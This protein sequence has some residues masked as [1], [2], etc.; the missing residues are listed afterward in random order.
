MRAIV[1]TRSVD[2][3]A[4]PERVWT[5]MAD[6]ERFN[7]LLGMS[8]VRYRPIEADNTTGARFL[9]ETR[10]GGFRLVY[11]EAPFEWTQPRAFSVQRRMRGGPIESYTTRCSFEP[12]EVRGGEGLEGG[13]RATLSFEIVPRLL[14]FRPIA[15]LNARRFMPRLAELGAHVDAHLTSGAPSLVHQ[16]RV[17]PSVR[18]RSN[19][20]SYA[21]ARR[22]S[23]RRPPIA[24]PRSFATAP[25]RTS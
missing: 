3:A 11:E 7:R 21:C 20:P 13:T 19:P 6:T 25:T 22:A 23:R 5:F 16:A 9:A 8:D 24:S 14:L 15:W 2:L 4:P 18:R 1:V 12:S 17:S 10:A